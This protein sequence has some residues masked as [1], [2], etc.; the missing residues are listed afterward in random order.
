MSDSLQE[1]PSIVMLPAS[2]LKRLETKLQKILNLIESQESS[3]PDEYLTA[4]EFMEKLKICRATFDQLRFENKIRVIKKGR[5]LYVPGSEV[6][7]Y[8]ERQ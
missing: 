8:F 5:K 1:Y 4:N 3:A 6:K 7:G 2:D